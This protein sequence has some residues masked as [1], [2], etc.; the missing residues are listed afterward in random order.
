MSLPSEPYWKNL[1]M[2]ISVQGNLGFFPIMLL[3]IFPA[4]I[5]Y[6]TPQPLPHF[7]VLV[8]A[9]SYFQVPKSLIVSQ[10]TITK[11]HTFS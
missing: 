1:Y 3:K 7:N 4:S 5:H 6:P 11:Y 10:T 2:H 8:T 9:A